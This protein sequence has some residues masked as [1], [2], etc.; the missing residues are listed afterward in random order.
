[1]KKLLLALMLILISTDT[2]AEWTK[3]FESE[4]KG[5]YTAYADLTTIR[6]AGHRVKMWT[7]LDYKI[8]QKASGVIFLSKTIRR[9]Y[10]CKEEHIRI[11]ASKL[12]SWNMEGGKRVRTYN[13]PQPWEELQ[14]EKK[15]E[16]GWNIACSES[17]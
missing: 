11:L 16:T 12:F 6:K 1:M 14:P 5:G 3:I 13:Q 9:D 10:D 4:D 17:E 8:E 15:D 7:L 2:I